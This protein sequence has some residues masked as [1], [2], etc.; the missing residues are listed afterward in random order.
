M[1]RHPSR[2]FRRWCAGLILMVFTWSLPGSVE[3]R[4]NPID[5][6]KF[7][8]KKPNFV[9]MVESAESMQ[10][11]PGENPARYNEV[12]ADCEK[13]DRFC[14]LY[15]QTGRCE[16]SA[17]GKQGYVFDEVPVYTGTS[18]STNTRTGGTKVITQTD[19]GS[20]T[21]FTTAVLTS[22]SANTGGATVSRT[23]TATT[24]S[25]GSQSAYQTGTRTNS[26]TYYQTA[27]QSAVQ[28]SYATGTITGTQTYNTT[29]T[30]TGTETYNTTTTKTGTET[31]YPSSTIALGTSAQSTAGSSSNWTFPFVLPAGNN[32][33]VVIFTGASGGG[34]ANIAHTV[35][36]YGTTSAINIGTVTFDAASNYQRVDA[37]VAY[38][39][40]SASACTTSCAVTG[41]SGSAIWNGWMEAISFSGV[42]QSTGATA[43]SNSSNTGI[44]SLTAN[45]TAGIS[46]LL[47]D[48]MVAHSNTTTLTQNASQTAIG[49]IQVVG[50]NRYIGYSTKAVSGA[51][52]TTWDSTVAWNSAGLLL[53]D[54][55]PA[56][57]TTTASRSVTTTNTETTTNIGNRTVTTTN[58]G[59]TTNI[60]N[61]T[62]TTTNT[63]TNTNI[64]T[65]S[66]TSTN[67]ATTTNTLSRVSSS[68]NTITTTNVTSVT[69]TQ[70]STTV[71]TM[72][73]VAGFLTETGTGLTTNTETATKTLITTAT[74]TATYIA[75]PTPDTENCD[76][77]SCSGS[78]F[79]YLQSTKSC[80]KDSDCST[81]GDFCR[82][83]KSGDAAGHLRND[84]CVTT[85]PSK[86]C[87]YQ[88]KSCLDHTSCGGSA[89]AT[90]PDYCVS[91]IPARMCSKTG[92]WC[93]DYDTSCDLDLSNTCEDATSRMMMVKNAVRRVIL[94]HSYDDSVVKLGHLHTYQANPQTSTANLFPY[95]QLAE[96]TFDRT[97]T[98]FL[99][100]SELQRGTYNSKPCFVEA[101]GPT[102]DCTI[103]YGGGGATTTPSV[104]YHLVT[105][106]SNSRYAIPTGDGRTFTHE[107]ET[108]AARATACS[109][110]SNFTS[111]ICRGQY[112][113]SYYTFTYRSGTPVDAG[114]DPNSPVFGSVKNPQYFS[115]YKGKS[116]GSSGNYWM[117]MD[118]E[119]SDIA[120]ENKY[121]AIDYSGATWSSSVTYPVPLVGASGDPMSTS[122]ACSAS[123]G[124]QWDYNLVPRVDVSTQGGHSLTPPQKGLLN[125]AR[126]EK[127]SFG[128]F[129]AVGNLQPVGCALKNDGENDSHHSVDGYMGEVKAADGSAC[130][131]SH[132]LLVV[133]GLPRG[134][135]DVAVGGYDCQAA[136][137]IYSATNQELTGCSCPVVMK[138]RSLAKD[139]GA[140]VHVIAASSNLPS[141]NNYAWATLNNIARAG[142]T[143]PSFINE[144]RLAGS[145]DALYYWLNYEMREALRVRV[146]TTPASAASGSQSLS[147]LSAGGMLY[148]TVA[149]LPEWRG[150]VVGYS[151]E[152]VAS[153]STATGTST[154][155]GTSTDVTY[156]TSP[157][158]DAARANGWV[159]CGAG[160]STPC[161]APDDTHWKT[162]RKVFFSDNSGNVHEIEVDDS[163]GIVD[164][165]IL[166]TLLAMGMGGDAAETQRIV[167]WMLGQ[168]D[169]TTTALGNNARPLNPAVMGSVTNSMPIEVG[170][171]GMSPLPGGNHFFYTHASRAPLLY[172]GADDGMLHAFHATDGTEAF[173]FIPADMIPVIT[174]LYTQ[175]GQR[176][177]PAEHIYG[178]S[179]SPKVKNV[180]TARCTPANAAACS[181]L[182]SGP[183]D[184]DTC[185]VWNTILIMPEGQGGNHPFA[186]DITDPF[187][188]GEVNLTSAKLLW[189]AGYKNT[190]LLSSLSGETMSVPAFAYRKTTDRLDQRALIASSN[191][192]VGFKLID[193]QLVT[194]ST[195]SVGSGLEKASTNLS[196]T[197]SPAPQYGMVA[198]VALARNYAKDGEQS[199]IAAYLADTWGF[200][201]QYTPFFTTTKS[202]VMD[203][204]CKHPLYFSPAV[205]QLDR[206]EAN[207]TA[208][209]AV[210]LAQVTNSLLD[211]DTRDSNEPSMLVIEKLTSIGSDPPDTDTTFGNQGYITLNAGENCTGTECLCGKKTLVTDSVPSQGCGTDGSLLPRRA[212]PT[213]TPVAVLRYDGRGFQLFTTWYAPPADNWDNCPNSDTNGTSYIT[214]HEF[215][216]NGT[217]TQLAG[218]PIT[219][220]YVTG[221]QF[222]GTTLFVTYGTN[223]TPP[224]PPD[225]LGNLGQTFVSV[226]QKLRSLAA[227]RFI[228]TAWTERLD[229]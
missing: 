130:W 139:H 55:A 158:W 164:G 21:K 54:L 34:S 223:E 93:S 192:G 140:S 98:R 190:T 117:L 95:V 205:V 138:A 216:D 100:R 77:N 23:T 148:Q 41:T 46:H 38:M 58:T 39:G 198:D 147:G 165:T 4:P 103:D 106:G 209:T 178:L 92:V 226:D 213:G 131:Q 145:E 167:G 225:G 87:R 19:T 182:E 152:T 156:R 206:N 197:R 3:A 110:S 172:V 184:N 88:A 52:S 112:E 134:P 51:S 173:A 2:A 40:N 154:G 166:N 189:H 229:Q 220:Q 90:G 191:P 157:L 50:G 80:T 35:V 76:S 186:L 211:S 180:C 61:R 72:S 109:N 31:Y 208:N 74:A 146:A 6:V 193:A 137:C 143:S 123:N 120:N 47:V 17:V 37:W 210:Y 111:P 14:R 215:L 30:V 81:K 171:P 214:V 86:T 24:T 113:G 135:G 56:P 187:V 201:H 26:E 151:I 227:E 141:I 175:G 168:L 107:D 13:G 62:V 70:T 57:L 65:R 7:Q 162:E 228:R 71:A 27:T 82:L 115:S 163:S 150:S 68:T 28:T 212:R 125:A 204:G 91:G 12:G 195:P 9:I 160:G 5:L 102:Q 116:Y 181:D 170:A 202:T 159:P 84:F 8:M 104:T 124:A 45:S 108:W 174:K 183:W 25:I 200:V 119:R 42:L 63:G 73:E 179:G 207:S 94:D 69:A 67:T 78:S 127:T 196:C 105:L 222:V 224:G 217:W 121:G 176:Y 79:C 49:T 203:L 15:A 1:N 53:V 194:A 83:I 44:K 32:R 16:F 29:S 118:A 221:V 101:T 22:T 66:V 218:V 185:P 126:F 64:E 153:T 114:S 59:T 75:Q 43:T 48:A 10:A 20:L 33:A 36:K 96:P 169:T 11:T 161:K 144:P 155:T 18:T 128:G 85:T 142:S 60:G 188:S 177:N 97:E 136:A 219:R 129:H 99:S 199:L 89:G 132:V 122:V 149:D 133:D